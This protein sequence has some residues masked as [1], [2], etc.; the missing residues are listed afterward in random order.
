[1]NFRAS[2]YLSLAL[3]LFAAL[4]AAN[5]GIAA[6]LSDV[7]KAEDSFVPPSSVWLNIRKQRAI[8][9]L[10]K[11]GYDLLILPF[12]TSDF[13]FDTNEQ[14]LLRLSLAQRIA[15]GSGVSVADPTLVDDALGFPQFEYSEADL[16]ELAAL[17]GA[18][19]LVMGIFGH[20]QKMSF[21]LRVLTA[22]IA[23]SPEGSIAWHQAADFQ[24]V[25]YSD[26]SPPYFKFLKFRDEIAE[27]IIDSDLKLPESKI[28]DSDPVMPASVSE[29]LDFS[30]TGPIDGA[31]RLQLLG[32]MHPQVLAN[33]SRLRLFERSL[34]LT[35]Y[36]DDGYKYREL[37]ISRALFY[38]NRRPAA[39]RT[40]A[41]PD[42]PADH[43]LLA[44]LNGNLPD[45]VSNQ[46]RIRPSILQL[47][48]VLEKERLRL[49]Y[50]G[51][52]SDDE[53]QRWVA[54]F[55]PWSPF[56]Y[57]ALNDNNRW[58]GFSLVPT[59]MGLDTAFPDTRFS[60]DSYVSGKSVTSGQLDEYEIAQ[61]ILNH[62][63]S[64]EKPEPADHGVAV[65]SL[66]PAARDVT[67]LARSMMV[68][69]IYNEVFRLYRLIGKPQRAVEFADRFNAI[70][71]DQPDIAYAKSNAK[72]T[73]VMQS[74]GPERNVINAQAIEEL[75][76]A[77][78]WAGM[79]NDNAGPAIRASSQVFP[80]SQSLSIERQKR[81]LRLDEWPPYPTPLMFGIEV[82]LRQ[83]NWQHCLK[84]TSF[85][86]QCLIE[87]HSSLTDEQ[88]PTPA[89]QAA[90]EANRN[91]FIGH[92]GP[93]RF[94]S[95]AI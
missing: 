31:H 74:R 63:D 77:F 60:L 86:L 7:D 22:D 79:I 9:Q 83:R 40:L 21:N 73:L 24:E 17:T 36:I 89:S 84:Y 51:A 72:S 61:L 3:A 39:L 76:K 57:G 6:N 64:I 27:K 66:A 16:L 78:L 92:P 81:H 4:T 25:R 88:E 19:K 94:S 10:R 15:S 91:R 87:Y 23:D 18:K 54:D 52:A 93:N 53:L 49:A 28:D 2:R 69:S 11:G 65:F 29:I 13:P 37:L 8:E 56:I 44:Y 80:G 67:E 50:G 75:R 5:L 71:P 33:R 70:V 12:S 82:E 43:H 58:K 41:A 42:T 47:Q 32:V 45:V 55:E 95:Q 59:K 1:M 90:I 62:T 38:L 35:E 20:D 26:E 30:S 14:E 34:I 68:E 46:E 48:A 85:Q